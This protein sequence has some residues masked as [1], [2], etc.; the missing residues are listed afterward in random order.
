MTIWRKSWMARNYENT[1]TAKIPG[2]YMTHQNGE[3][4]IEYI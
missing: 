3:N 4:Q 1:V 2:S